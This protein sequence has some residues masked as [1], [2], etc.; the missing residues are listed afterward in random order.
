[1]NSLFS[2]FFWKLPG[3]ILCVCVRLF[4]DYLGVILEVFW[5]D[6]EG[7]TTKNKCQNLIFYYLK[8]AL[9]SLFNEFFQEISRG[10]FGVCV[11][12]FGGHFG[13]VLEGFW[14]K[15]NRKTNKIFR[16]M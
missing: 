15:N 4:G 14:R 13:G 10:H 1:M 6:F 9:N 5:E 2:E 11:T 8:T 7:Q 3:G 16:K 12:L